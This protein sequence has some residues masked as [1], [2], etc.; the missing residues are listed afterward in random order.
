MCVCV[1]VK[2]IFFVGPKREKVNI[3]KWIGPLRDFYFFKNYSFR[4]YI[5]VC[6]QLVAFVREHMWHKAIWMEHPVRLKLTRVM[7]YSFWNIYI[8]EDHEI[9]FQI[10]FVWAFLLIVHT[11]NSNPFR[12]NL[13][14]LQCTCCTVQTTSGRPHGSP[15]V[16][17]CQWPLSQ[18]LPSPQL[19]HNDSLWA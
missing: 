4:F 12:S 15:L 5:C 10:F 17:A 1:S 13:L 16:W 3:S 11:W 18:P 7:T 2:K 9:I 14:R 19:S 8:Y 6:F